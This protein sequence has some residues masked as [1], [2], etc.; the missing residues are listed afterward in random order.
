MSHAH[1]DLEQRLA[2]SESSVSES[3]LITVVLLLISTSHG[4]NGPHIITMLGQ[5]ASSEGS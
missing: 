3:V 4:R 1:T 2:I 5:F